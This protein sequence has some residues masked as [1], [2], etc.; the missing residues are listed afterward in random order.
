[1][2]IFE[3]LRNFDSTYTEIIA[4]VDEAGRGP[5]AGPVVAAAVILD[6][7]KLET[8]HEINDS[9]KIPEA[10]R[11]M[12]FDI[13]R[14][15]CIAYA[16]AEISHTGIDKSDILSATMLA[17]ANAVKGLKSQPQLILVDGISRPPIED[18]KIETIIS[19]DAKS[20]SIAAAS[21]L[22]KVHRDRVMRNYDLMYPVYGFGK[23]KGY[24]TAVHMKALAEY[25]VCPIHRL[26]Y[27]PVAEAAKKFKK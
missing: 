7:N 27:K 16:I 6:K 22:A 9:K 24:G 14:E 1:M 19:G 10:K 20:L 8:L 21:I 12:L 17:M 15:A 4:G 11:E 13:V 5:W 3:K 25:G 23:H 2:N 26:S 18:I